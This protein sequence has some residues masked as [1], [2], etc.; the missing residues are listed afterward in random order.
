MLFHPDPHFEDE[1]HTDTCWLMVIVQY[2]GFFFS[3]RRRYKRSYGDWS[4]DVCSSDLTVR[5]DLVV[6]H[7]R[8]LA[9]ELVGGARHHFGNGV[10]LPATRN[11]QRAARRLRVDLRGGIRQE[12]RK[13]RLEQRP[14]GRR[15]VV[16]RVQRVGFLLRDGVA[17]AEEELLR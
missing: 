3:S 1:L 8:V 2:P 12:V 7:A 11:Q 17:E 15:D 6:G 4:S 5:E 14:P 13:C 16:F 10:I 9:I